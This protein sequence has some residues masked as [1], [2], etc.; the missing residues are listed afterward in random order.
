MLRPRSHGK[1]LILIRLGLILT[2][3][4]STYH[5][6]LRRKKER[7][8]DWLHEVEVT[9]DD[10]QSPGASEG[11]N[12][13]GLSGLSFNYII[14]GITERVFLLSSQDIHES[15]NRNIY[16]LISD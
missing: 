13:A 11:D 10:R 4:S 1:R 7:A 8:K 9:E 15:S 16:A 6:S 5:T 3:T 2:R 12:Y 14:E